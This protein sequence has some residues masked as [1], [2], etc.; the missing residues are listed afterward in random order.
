MSIQYMAEKSELK[1]AFKSDLTHCC[2]GL[3]KS[4]RPSLIG[5][6]GGSRP[7]IVDLTFWP[8]APSLHCGTC[9][10]LADQN[11][12]RTFLW[13]ISVHFFNV[14]RTFPENVHR[15]FLNVHRT[16]LNVQRIF[17]KCTV[18]NVHRTLPKM[19]SG[20]FLWCPT[21]LRWRCLSVCKGCWILHDP[22]ATA[23]CSSL[24]I[25]ADSFRRL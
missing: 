6:S 10:T 17:K 11:S 15:T 12:F 19:F 7:T 9:R 1:K 21:A 14:H 4:R 24:R 23:G 8:T 18:Q 2:D 22:A 25:E 5:K 3:G 16:F 13:P 20:I